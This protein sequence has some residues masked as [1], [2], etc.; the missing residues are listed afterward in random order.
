[1]SATPH[2]RIALLT[3]LLAGSVPAQEADLQAACNDTNIRW[4]LPGDFASAQQRAQHERRLLL[5][6]GISFGVDEAGATCAT[7]GKW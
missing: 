2:L 1:M 6:K 5:I 3:A 4:V 7:K